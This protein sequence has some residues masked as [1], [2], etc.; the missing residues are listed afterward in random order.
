MFVSLSYIVFE[1]RVTYISL[2]RTHLDERGRKLTIRSPPEATQMPSTSAQSPSSTLSSVG[3]TS[4]SDSPELPHTLSIPEHSSPSSALV[5]S[6]PAWDPFETSHKLSPAW[7][8]SS[9]LSPH[10]GSP[11]RLV[12]WLEEPKLSLLR[13]KLKTN[14]ALLQSPYVE[15]LG[16]ENGRVKVRDK[17]D[18]KLLAL[19]AVSPLLPTSKGDLIIPKDGK[20]QGIHFS[21]VRI[22]SN[23]CVVRKPGTRPTKQNPDIEFAIS[24]LVQVYPPPRHKTRVNVS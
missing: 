4:A 18:I 24:D 13:L 2:L 11:S 3:P 6:T 15:F 22:T 12:H 7:C 20:L 17:M 5:G 1:S 21:V 8:P 9:V 23:L 10:T 16:V 14:D 19:E